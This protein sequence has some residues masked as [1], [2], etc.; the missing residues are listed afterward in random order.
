MTINADPN[1]PPIAK[2]IGSRI[3][4]MRGK[5]DLKQAD[6]ARKASITSTTLWRYERGDIVAGAE[7]LTRL[8]RE[9]GVSL[10]WLIT[11]S[12]RSPHND[13]DPSPGEA[14]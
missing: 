11:G 4:E 14:A 1:S 5:R 12:E 9:L 2:A 6:L 7:V 13:I 10:D 8:A 3:V